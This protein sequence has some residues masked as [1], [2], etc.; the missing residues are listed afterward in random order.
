MSE[1]LHR[2]LTVVREQLR[3]AI[4]AS[5]CHGCGC[6]QKTVDALAGTDA[7]RN[8][9]APLLAE[10]RRTFVQKKYD[11]LGCEVCW[12]AVAANAFADAFP[13]IAEGLDLCPTEAP[14]ERSGWPPLP[15]DYHVIRY[16]A[17]VAVCTLNNAQLAEA[18][19]YRPPEGLAIVG[20]LSTEN[21]G[22]ERIIRNVISN[23][24]IRYLVLCG[25]DTQQAIGH[26]PGQSAASLHAL[27]VDE[28]GRIRGAR[29]KRPVLKNLRGDEI[30]AFRRQVE[31]ISMIGEQRES[32]I[33]A[34][35]DRCDRSVGPFPH[36]TAS[37]AAPNIIAADEPRRLIPDPAG[38]FVIY[39]DRSRSRLVVEHFTNQAVLGCVIEGR[40]P[41]AIY[42]EAIARGLL[43]RLDH[44]AYLGRELARA[45]DSLRTGERYIQDRA[46]GEIEAPTEKA[47]ST[48]HCGPSCGGQNR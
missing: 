17:P 39:P 38:F 36:A 42:S 34:A 11:C 41:A 7:G 9:L 24:H 19:A 29:G 48:C 22:I 33:V 14:D 26:L 47:D 16:R 27:G 46:P 10:A 45:A 8:G 3:E 25:E 15:G 37:V 6:F 28:Q 31:L 32:E 21:L 1:T 43:T 13:G 18:H 2:S 35:V 12:P 23:P 20:T 44:A 40:T 30:E 5:K 4:S